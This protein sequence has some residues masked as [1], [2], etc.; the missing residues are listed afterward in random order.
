MQEWNTSNNNVDTFSIL[1][2]T[3]S[4]KRLSRLRSC[5][6]I[7][8]QKPANSAAKNSPKYLVVGGKGPRPSVVAEISRRKMVRA[9]HVNIVPR[10][11]YL[12]QVENELHQ[13]GENIL[14]RPHCESPRLSPRN[15]QRNLTEATLGDRGY[16]YTL[17]VFERQRL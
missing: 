2:V 10:R 8:C 12:A 11:V 3:A 1:G 15:I 16:V 17:I 7:G 13:R 9:S 4:L 14:I 5:L 6:G